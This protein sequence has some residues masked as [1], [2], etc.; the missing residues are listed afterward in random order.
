MKRVA[1]TGMG[2]IDTLGNSPE[3]CYQNFVSKQYKDPTPYKDCKVE[4]YQ[5]QNVF[6]VDLEGLD[7]PEDIKPATLNNLE[8]GVKYSLHSIKQALAD[9]GV[10]HS[11]NVATIAS[12]I[13]AG[14]QY[15]IDVYPKL[16]SET[17]R[18]R[19]RQLL[20]TTKDFLVGM[21]TEH[22]G[23]Q[24]PSTSLYAACATSLFNIDYAMRFVDDYDYV[25]CTVSDHG[26]NETDISF[27]SQLGA[28]GTH[29]APW[30]DNRD[31]FIMGEGGACFILE[32]EEKA[33]ARGAKIHAYLYPVGFGSDA[34]N[35]TSPSTDGVGAKAAMRNAIKG[36]DKTQI[37]FVNAHGT[38]TP[39]GDEIE[40]NAILDVLGSVETLSCKS[41][42]GHTMGACGMIEAI[43]S[44]MALKQ[45][46][47]PD[48][49][50]LNACSF[51]LKKIITNTNRKTD[52]RFAINNSFG[53]GGKCASQVIEIKINETE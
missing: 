40:Y 16:Y 5:G 46:T 24:G 8:R 36:I 43:Y 41:K 15:I 30:D 6:P 39:A 38:S 33:K 29:S 42:I 17:G 28:L 1:I 14:N 47:I 49:H 21:L 12:N 3:V 13:T 26:I 51:D 22:Y 53:F 31:G 27:F 4:R 10:S 50:N 45:G 37:G 48:N 9:S 19:P 44:I 11:S 25:I 7:L 35:A 23:W 2:M 32:S 52:K 34:F 20:G 18:C